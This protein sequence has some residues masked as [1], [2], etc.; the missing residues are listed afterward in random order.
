MWKIKEREKRN[1]IITPINKLNEGESSTLSRREFVK[2]TTVLTAAALS[3][4][5]LYSLTRLL[6]YAE[7]NGRLT[8]DTM[9]FMD[10]PTV[11]TLRKDCYH[12]NI[13]IRLDGKNE[14]GENVYHHVTL[15]IFGDSMN[16]GNG[17]R[18]ASQGVN[19][20][21]SWGHYAVD[22]A[23]SF[24][25]K[26]GIKGKWTQIN[27][28][29]PGSSTLGL[30][31]FELPDG[32]VQLG[33]RAMQEQI[34]KDPNTPVVAIGVNGNNWRESGKRALDLYNNVDGN[35]PNFK[36]FLDKLDLM[37]NNTPLIDKLKAN[38]SELLNLLLNDHVLA[39]QVDGLFQLI[40]KDSAEFQK[41][42]N[43]ALKIVTELNKKRK[44]QK[45]TEIRLVVTLPIDMQLRDVIPYTPPNA[46]RDE[47]GKIDYAGIPNAGGAVYRIT[48]A[49]YQS[50]SQQLRTFGKTADF[51]EFTTVPFLGFETNPYLFAKDG[52][53]AP[54]G[55]EDASDEFLR[56]ASTDD[57]TLLSRFN[58]NPP[59]SPRRNPV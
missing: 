11:D 23:N 57:Q 47:R 34:V 33:N 26:K 30:S 13:P 59:R 38:G 19:Q 4:R 28:A 41:G 40:Q 1:G 58:N 20:L 27:Q 16:L 42:F 8:K 52:H 45:K 14:K 55:E 5:A 12:A 56:H 32:N 31:G 24:F 54:I 44:K 53:F 49:I 3:V 51:P 36:P 2:D 6:P 18:Y 46:P 15:Y 9:A 39:Q 25:E 35:S 22:K 48:A 50:V 37:G 10:V 29:R 43:K 7:S 21:L 17:I